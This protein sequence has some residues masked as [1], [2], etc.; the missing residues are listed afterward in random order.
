MANRFQRPGYRAI[1]ILIADSMYAGQCMPASPGKGNHRASAGQAADVIAA[2]TKS[3]AKQAASRPSQHMDKARLGQ[4]AMN[5][6]NMIQIDG[7]FP[8]NAAF[9]FVRIE[10]IN[11]RNLQQ[12]RS[13]IPGS[14]PRETLTG[15]PKSLPV[16]RTRGKPGQQKEKPVAIRLPHHDEAAPKARKPFLADAMSGGSSISLS[17]V[18][19]DLAPTTIGIRGK[20]LFVNRHLRCRYDWATTTNQGRNKFER[21]S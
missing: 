11:A 13:S 12:C 19:P 4:K 14:V 1:K 7:S 5:R 9:S 16:G 20:I 6:L 17:K 2:E 18:V 21:Q 8:P 10:S 3:G 15:M